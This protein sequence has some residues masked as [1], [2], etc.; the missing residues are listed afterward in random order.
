MGAD[1]RIARIEVD[2]NVPPGKIQVGGVW[3]SGNDDESILVALRTRLVKVPDAAAALRLRDEL[4][5]EFE[6]YL[7]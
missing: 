4:E 5:G 6:V 3:I 7:A 2:P 1:R